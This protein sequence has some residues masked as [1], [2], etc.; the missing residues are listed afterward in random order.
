[1][2]E[3]NAAGRITDAELVAQAERG[4]SCSAVLPALLVR[5]P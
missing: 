4:P 3:K 2:T 1:M 5:E